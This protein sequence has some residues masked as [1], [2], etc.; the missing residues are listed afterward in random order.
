MEFVTSIISIR[1]TVTYETFQIKLVY[2]KSKSTNCLLSLRFLI[3]EE[4]F[5][6]SGKTREKD[7][8]FY[9]FILRILIWSHIFKILARERRKSCFS[10]LSSALGRAAGKMIQLKL[11][12][13]NTKGTGAS[14]RC[15][16]EALPFLVERRENPLWPAGAWP[17]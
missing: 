9:I 10:H 6:K 7:N 17:W 3:C 4:L 13:T 16:V 11:A 14:I 1:W 15:L 8:N 2:P 12:T 5:D